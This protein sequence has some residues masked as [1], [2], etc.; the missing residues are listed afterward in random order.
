MDQQF[1][2]DARVLRGAMKGC[3]TDEATIISVIGHRTNAQRIE[4]VT[5]YKASFGRDLIADLKDELGG[6]FEDAA[7]AMFKSPL[8]YDVDEL[9]RAMKGGGTAEDVLIEIIGSRSNS[10]L[11]EIKELYKEKYNKSLEDHVIDETSSDLKRLLVSLLQ[12]N[13]SENEVASQEQA[14]Q[15][16]TELFQAGEGQMGTDESVFNRIFTLRSPAEVLAMAI[17]YEQ[18]A[19]KSILTSIESE[20]SGDSKVLLKSIAQALIYPSQYFASLI[21]KATKGWGTDDGTLIRVL[22][23]RDEIDLPQIKAC[24]LQMYGM[25]LEE[26]IKDECSGDYKRL[27]LALASH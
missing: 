24:F 9:Y 13:R 6:N 17:S 7:I 14:D 15:D 8:E 25:S 4:I 12:C 16:A 22:V 23:S 1:E 2:E 3:G 11:Q 19:G 26:E 27:L 20:F 21:R 18:M 10:R 5:F